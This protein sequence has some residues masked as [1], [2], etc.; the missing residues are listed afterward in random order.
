VAQAEDWVPNYY[1]NLLRPL[2]QALSFYLIH[3]LCWYWCTII[4]LQNIYTVS[5]PRNLRNGAIR[6]PWPTRY[7]HWERDG[8]FSNMINTIWN[9]IFRLNLNS[10]FEHGLFETHR[11]WY[12]QASL[13]NKVPPLR[14][15]WSFCR[16]DQYSLKLNFP[17]DFEV[18][19]QSQLI[20]Q[21]NTR[22]FSYPR[23][24]KFRITFDSRGEKLNLQ[25]QSDRH[26][27]V[28]IC[29]VQQTSNCIN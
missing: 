20:P 7:H 6:R 17:S 1:K 23:A 22:G 29:V 3:I 24:T 14:T 28:V 4:H 13:T 2:T 10:P 19:I 18:T 5:L 25:A 27:C 9:W 16:H 15:G 11:G 21:R 12:H 8:H 26:N